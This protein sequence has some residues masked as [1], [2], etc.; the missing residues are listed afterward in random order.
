MAVMGGGQNQG[1]SWVTANTHLAFLCTRTLLN[2]QK[3]IERGHGKSLVDNV[4]DFDLF[5]IKKTRSLSKIFDKRWKR[6]VLE[7]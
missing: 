6:N 2:A 7:R 3:K 1:R 4:K 5:Y